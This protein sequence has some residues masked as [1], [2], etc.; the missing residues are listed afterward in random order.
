M[1]SMERMLSADVARLLDRLAGSIPEGALADIRK[2]TPTMCAR[3][4]ELESHLTKSYASLVEA[5]GRWTQT[6]DDVENIWA[7]AVCRATAEEPA[8]RAPRLAA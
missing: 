2:R 6:L 3:L 8:E 4:D 7:L 1:N 5:Y